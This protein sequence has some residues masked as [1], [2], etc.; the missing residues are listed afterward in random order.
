M[1]AKSQA[2]PSQ[3]D[4]S[5][6]SPSMMFL[7]GQK[8]LTYLSVVLRGEHVSVRG[9][10]RP[11]G[12]LFNLDPQTTCSSSPKST[13]K[14]TVKIPIPTDLTTPKKRTSKHGPKNIH[15]WLPAE[16]QVRQMSV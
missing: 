12:I 2:N 7:D 11:I 3:C 13:R 4:T 9:R 16:I 14:T 6:G 10:K 1:T 8:R 5:K 15:R